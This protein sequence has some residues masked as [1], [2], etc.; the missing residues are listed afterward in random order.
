MG[1]YVAFLGLRS[2]VHEVCVGLSMIHLDI[3]HQ[4]LGCANG[5]SGNFP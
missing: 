3:L 1:G 2:E 4:E 5:E